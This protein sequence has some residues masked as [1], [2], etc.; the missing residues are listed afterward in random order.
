MIR[1][2]GIRKPKLAILGFN[3]HAGE[4]GIL[5]TEEN[6]III[7]A[8]NLAKEENII[9]IGPFPADGYFG[10]G[11]FSSYDATLAMYHDQGLAPFKSIVFEEGVNF[12]A[13]LPAVRTSP[14]HGTAFQLAG[15]NEAR[16]DSF[17]NA[18]FA[19]IDIYKNRANLDEITKDSLQITDIPDKL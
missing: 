3:P 1:D 12:T 9:A 15:K 6:E 18:L 2:F 8:I 13:G 16:H 5:G 17:R 4:E 7:P 11:E 19:A 14:A 10:S